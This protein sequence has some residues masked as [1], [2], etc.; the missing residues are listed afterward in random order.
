MVALDAAPWMAYS[1]SMVRNILLRFNSSTDTLRTV[2]VA[3]GNLCT[4]CQPLLVR[5]PA[6]AHSINKNILTVHL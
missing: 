6:V 4:V 5:C 2:P 1:K 3:V